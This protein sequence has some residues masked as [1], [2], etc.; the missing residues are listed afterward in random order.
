MPVCT[1]V[2]CVYLVPTESSTSVCGC[3]RPCGVQRTKP[4]SPETATSPLSLSAIFPFPAPPYFLRQGV[5]PNLELV[6]CSDESGRP[7]SSRIFL[8]H[9][10]YCGL[11]C[12]HTSLCAALWML[13]CTILK[14][15]PGKAHSDSVSMLRVEAPVGKKTVSDKCWLEGRITMTMYK[16]KG[17]NRY[18]MNIWPTQVQV[19]TKTLVKPAP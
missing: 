8:S 16:P 11:R 13:P 9:L 4:R 10:Q 2:A 19:G 18:T 7:G 6:H 12:M 1:Q 17:M 5:S 14:G 3:E 15:R